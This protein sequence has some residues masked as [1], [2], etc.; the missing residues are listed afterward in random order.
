MADRGQQIRSL[1]SQDAGIFRLTADTSHR[2]RY[3]RLKQAWEHQLRPY[4]GIGPSAPGDIFMARIAT[5]LL[6]L[7]AVPGCGVDEQLPERLR[8]EFQ[9]WTPPAD[10][11]V[12]ATREYRKVRHVALTADYSTNASCDLIEQHY[13]D[14]LRKRGWTFLSVQPNY[15]WSRHVGDV[16]SYCRG[17]LMATVECNT[18][19]AGRGWTYNVSIVWPSKSACSR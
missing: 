10:A 2:A 19:R 1:A 18:D 3:P 16:A 15:I 9:K 4:H 11:H 8:T 17:D 14:L 13:S 5:V 12:I 6:L 7:L